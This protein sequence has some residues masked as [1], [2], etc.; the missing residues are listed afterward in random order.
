MYRLLPGDYQ[1]NR[2]RRN[3]F[4]RRLSETISTPILQPPPQP[5][6]RDDLDDLIFRGEGWWVSDR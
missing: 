6:P 3:R 5:A 1:W 4:M 2:D